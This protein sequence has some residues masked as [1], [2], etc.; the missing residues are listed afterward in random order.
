MFD[1]RCSGSKPMKFHNP[2]KKNRASR[3]MSIQ[4]PQSVERDIQAAAQEMAYHARA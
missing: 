1:I 3:S 2:F 4:D